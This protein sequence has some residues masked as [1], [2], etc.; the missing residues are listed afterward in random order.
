MSALVGSLICI[1][2]QASKSESWLW[3]VLTMSNILKNKMS[4]DIL[5]NE[6]NPYFEEH[7]YVKQ[8]NIE[9]GYAA[10]ETHAVHAF[11]MAK[12]LYLRDKNNWNTIKNA[13]LLHQSLETNVF[14]GILNAIQRQ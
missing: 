1:E 6:I 3:R 7:L 9:P 4:M 13:F 10:E 11:I 5:Q 2:L 8:D 12:Q 14:D